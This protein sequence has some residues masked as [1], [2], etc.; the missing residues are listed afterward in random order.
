MTERADFERAVRPDPLVSVLVI[1]YNQAHLIGATLDSALSQEYENLEVVV[2]DD[3]STDDTPR[4]LREYAARFPER[5]VVVLNERNLG[6]T[7]NCNT[8]L[9][10]CTGEFIA[11]LGGDDLFLPGKIRAQV[12]AF[13]DDRAVVLS[14][15]PVEIFQSETGRTIYVT[16]QHP[17]EDTRNA[18]EIIEKCGIPGASSVMVRRSACPAKGFDE[19]IRTAGDWM[20]MIEVALRGKVVKVDQVLA[21]YRKHAG[22]I[23]NQWERYADDF[24]A[25]LDLVVKEYPEHPELVDVC[26]RGRA[27]F[28]AGAAF[29]QLTG[30]DT[31]RAQDLLRR[32]IREDPR[33]F[34]YDVCLWASRLPMVGRIAPHMKYLLKRWVA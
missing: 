14:Y 18:K 9:A 29:R 16:N 30:G 4:I 12:K 31:A 8:A 15:H 6:I 10:A 1:T 33:S 24:M 27:R 21:R 25:T 17:R 19:R 11:I 23:G 3:A 26:R 28:L 5:L 7:G 34:R 2:A 20:F 13:V 32:A 22:N